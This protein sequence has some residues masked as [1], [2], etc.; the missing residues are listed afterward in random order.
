MFAEPMFQ[1]RRPMTAD[2]AIEALTDFHF[3]LGENR[4][5]EDW[6]T[7]ASMDA[8]AAIR[9]AFE[10]RNTVGDL[11]TVELNYA[12]ALW[13][14]ISEVAESEGLPVE[15]TVTFGEDMP[16]SMSVT[17]KRDAQ[18]SEAFAI[19]ARARAELAALEAELPNATR[20]GSEWIRYKMLKRIIGEE[21]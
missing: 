12:L 7:Q 5:P 1:T 2:E 14:K 19:A 9:E 15:V 13:R 18:A 6:E 20:S 11:N 17:A 10:V 4:A 21:E 16:Q 8:K 3:A